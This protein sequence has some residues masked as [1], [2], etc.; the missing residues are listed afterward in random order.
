[1][2]KESTQEA[3]SVHTKQLRYE[4]KIADM[5]LTISKLQASLRDAQKGSSAGDGANEVS[6]PDGEESNQVKLL[7]EEGMW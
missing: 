6:Q 2:S 3:S 4:R 7:S 1:M 5:S